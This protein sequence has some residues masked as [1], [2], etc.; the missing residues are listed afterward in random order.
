ITIMEDLARGQPQ[1]LR[2]R[3]N[4]SL[5]LANLGNMKRDLGQLD[6]A[7]R[8]YRESL[9]ILDELE[10]T[11]PRRDYLRR[12]RAQTLAHFGTLERIAARPKAALRALRQAL[13]INDGIAEPVGEMLYDRACAE[14]QLLALAEQPATE[15]LPTDRA[16]C[17][18]AADRAMADLRRAVAMG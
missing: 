5:Y 16:D 3:R 8:S 7:E 2:Y 1:V 4:W 13:A 12:R 10:G 17:L 11:D 18:A 15:L 6:E 9:R 14:S